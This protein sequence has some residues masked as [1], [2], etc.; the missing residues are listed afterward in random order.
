MK[1]TDH[2]EYMLCIHC[3]LV[4][5]Q[6]AAAWLYDQ[7]PVAIMSAILKHCR[8]VSIIIVCR[9]ICLIFDL[10][11]ICFTQIKVDVLE[12]KCES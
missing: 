11:Q 4:V 12:K 1:S 7:G 9:D 6:L 10:V 3:V 5:V 8:Y 2:I